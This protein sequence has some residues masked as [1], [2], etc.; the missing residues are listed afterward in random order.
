M[1][2]GM[3]NCVI[4]KVTKIY[5]LVILVLY[6]VP[7]NVYRFEITKQFLLKFYTMINNTMLEVQ[8]TD[9]TSVEV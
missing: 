7:L 5:F 1:Y 8:D 4:D 9:D 3:F 2:I 6:L